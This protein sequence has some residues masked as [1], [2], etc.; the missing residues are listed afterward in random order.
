MV[1]LDGSDP[2]RWLNSFR[3]SLV[4]EIRA[5]PGRVEA[6]GKLGSGTVGIHGCM[7]D[8]RE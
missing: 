1:F 7:E 3:L 5:F 6:D 8:E 2:T 4:S